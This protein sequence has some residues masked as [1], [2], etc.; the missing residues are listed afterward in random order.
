MQSAL[1]EWLTAGVADY[2]G[3]AKADILSREKSPISLM[4]EG[5]L[6]SLSNGEVRALLAYLRT[7][8]QVPLTQP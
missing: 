5:L 6:K 3:D 4:P 7:T 2:D 1:S 8:S